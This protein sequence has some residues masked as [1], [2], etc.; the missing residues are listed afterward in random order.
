M[1]CTSRSSKRLPFSR[2]TAAKGIGRH[3]V[4]PWP[5][6]SHEPTA[7]IGDR[8]TYSGGCKAGLGWYALVSAGSGNQYPNVV[9]WKVAQTDVRVCHNDSQ[10]AKNEV[11]AVTEDI[12][13]S[14]L[15]MIIGEAHRNGD[16]QALF[17]LSEALMQQRQSL[18]QSEQTM[19][20]MRDELYQ[21]SSALKSNETAALVMTYLPSSELG[22]VNLTAFATYQSLVPLHG[23]TLA[24]ATNYAAATKTLNWWVEQLETL[25]RSA[26]NAGWDIREKRSAQELQSRDAL[27]NAP[28][29][30]SDVPAVETDE[31]RRMRDFMDALAAPGALNR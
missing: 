8:L 12:A 26:H 20:R 25:E 10:E 13:L 30:R 15:I 29:F 23:A 1:T 19:T 18:E 21:T 17:A 4:D 22:S 7:P 11:D 28:K 16:E 9:G 14:A 6:S 3:V 2:S 24:A 27:R 5:A 31:E